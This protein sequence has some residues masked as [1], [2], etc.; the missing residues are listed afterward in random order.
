MLRSKGILSEADK[1]W[2]DEKPQDTASDKSALL[3]CKY[4]QFLS[5][6]QR[7]SK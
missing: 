3:F 1:K 4:K 2:K 6:R 7:T 5:C